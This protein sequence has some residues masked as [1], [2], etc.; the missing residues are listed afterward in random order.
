MTFPV[1]IQKMLEVEVGVFLCR[2]QAFMTEELLDDP[3]VR[4]SAQQVGSKGMAKGMRTDLPS[5][6]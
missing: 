4:S 3:Q 6:G 2:G 1:D 5:Q